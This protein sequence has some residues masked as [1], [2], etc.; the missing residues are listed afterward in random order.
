MERA[1]TDEDIIQLQ[2][3]TLALK[4]ELKKMAGP[5]TYSVAHKGISMDMVQ[6]P[7]NSV[8]HKGISMDMV[9][10]PTNSVAHKGISMDM[11]KSTITNSRF[12]FDVDYLLDECGILDLNAASMVLGIFSTTLNVWG[13]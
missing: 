5:P 7:T 12:I 13:Y 11:V 2:T 10:P 9:Q 1:I 6:P 8:A 4:N 3:H